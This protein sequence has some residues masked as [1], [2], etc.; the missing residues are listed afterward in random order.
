VRNTPSGYLAPSLQGRV[1]A[2]GSLG[3]FVRAPV[4]PGEILAVWGGSIV[5]ASELAVG[6]RPK[7]LALQIEDEL[8]LVSECEGPMDWV[9]HSC[10]PNAGM[11]GQVT[12]V[13]MRPISLGEE[14]CY[15]YAMSDGSSYDEFD[16]ACGAA[17]CRRRI[18]G[19]DWQ[20]PELWPRY[21]GHFSTYLQSRIDR[22]RAT[23]QPAAETRA[24]RAA[25]TRRRSA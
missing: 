12:L 23:Q 18:T 3:V 5:T 14:V 2:D 21:E 17:H 25:R 7:R 1:K 16:C 10:D 8:F 15:D 20:R 19:D 24:V 11:R 4:G 9:N 22:W 6:G 13:A